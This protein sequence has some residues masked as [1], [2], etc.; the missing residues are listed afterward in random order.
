MN[1]SEFQKFV[2]SHID[3]LIK[4]HDIL[5][6]AKST[7]PYCIRTKKMMTDLKLDFS[8]INIDS[9]DDQ[10]VLRTALEKKT[11]HRTVPFVFVKNHFIGGSSD[12]EF[13]V[14]SGGLKQLLN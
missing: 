5:V 4:K 10:Y 1:E 14:S 13:I 9:I 2:S 7:C 12:F 3:D 11:N 8:W 6:F